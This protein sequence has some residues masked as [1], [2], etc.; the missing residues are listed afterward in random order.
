VSDSARRWLRAWYLLAAATV[1]ICL[2]SSFSPWT[3]RWNITASLPEGLYLASEYRGQDLQRHEIACFAYEPPAWAASRR[4]YEPG[5]VLCKYV[6]AVPG[7]RIEIAGRTVS[8]NERGRPARWLG[9]FVETD[10]R[11]RPVKPAVRERFVLQ[12]SQYWL[13]STRH[14]YS[15]DSRYLGPIARERVLFTLT[16]LLT[17]QL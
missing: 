13:G 16:P 5:F 6:L 1:V 9:D 2:F 11:G 7:D 15:F 4:Y 14:S 17:R 3:L 10:S 12:P 8:A